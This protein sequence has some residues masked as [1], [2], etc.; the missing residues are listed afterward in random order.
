MKIRTQLVL[1]CFLLSIVPLAAIVLYSYRSSRSALE[2]AYHAEAV[3]TIRQMDRRLAAIRSD[4]QERLAEL[5]A[6]PLQIPNGKAPGSDRR[7]ANDVLLA[8]GDSARLIDSLEVQPMPR[9][10]GSTGPVTEPSGSNPRPVSHA[11]EAG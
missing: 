4:L 5:T 6:F 9:I 10:S 7:M 3:R 8:L 1:A 11:R 2:T